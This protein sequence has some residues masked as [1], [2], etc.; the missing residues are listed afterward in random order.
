MNF[1]VLGPP[2]WRGPNAHAYIAYWIIWNWAMHSRVVESSSVSLSLVGVIIVT[3]LADI[4]I[5]LVHVMA[6]YYNTRRRH[7][8]ALAIER[9]HWKKPFE[10]NQ[11]ILY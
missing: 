3:F 7:L 6:F 11:T 9:R 2:F 5:R 8:K 1:D 4:L 10:E